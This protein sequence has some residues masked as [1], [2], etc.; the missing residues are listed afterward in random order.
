[1]KYSVDI[2]VRIVSSSFCASISVYHRYVSICIPF[3]ELLDLIQCIVQHTHCIDE[4]WRFV[5]VSAK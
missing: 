5:R 1:M 3:L 2:H 4:S